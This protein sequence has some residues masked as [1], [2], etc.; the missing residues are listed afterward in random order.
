MFWDNNDD[1]S[2]SNKTEDI[3]EITLEI[4]PD[5]QV[6]FDMLSEEQFNEDH[7]FAEVINDDK[8]EMHEVRLLR[9]LEEYKNEKIKTK[10]FQLK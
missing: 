10:P 2:I 7:H 5:D 6:D 4:N 8:E 1:T 3:E 9:L